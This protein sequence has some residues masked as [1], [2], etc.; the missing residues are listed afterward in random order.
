MESQK[1]IKIE[2]EQRNVKKNWRQQL[3]IMDWK[4]TAL[5]GPIDKWPLNEVKFVEAASFDEDDNMAG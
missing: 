3:N 1:R 5:W 4:E 2:K